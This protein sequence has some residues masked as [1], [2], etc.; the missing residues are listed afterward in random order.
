ML[1]RQLAETSEAVAATRSRIR[2]I[3][4]LQACLRQFAAH[5]IETGT[6]YLI[7]TLRQGRIG[8]GPS[9]VRH[10]LGVAASDAPRLTVGDVDAAFEQLAAVSGKGSNLERKRVL[11]GLFGLA[12]ATEQAFLARLML[13]ELRQGA[14]EGVMIDAIAKAA[15]CRFGMF[16]AQ[17]CSRGIRRRSP[18]LP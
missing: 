18:Q 8:L 11:S 3:D 1:L 4:L 12:T 14:L 13:G 16:A 2:K 7:G 10:A 5:E 17:S 6:G 15:G 9:M